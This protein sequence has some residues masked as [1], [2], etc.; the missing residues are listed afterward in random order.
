MTHDET[1][2]TDGNKNEGRKNGKKT[3]TEHHFNITPQQDKIG[4]K[5]TKPSTHILPLRPSIGRIQSSK[6][7]QRTTR[8]LSYE[9]KLL[10][11][12]V[13]ISKVN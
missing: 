12:T 11:S 13:S 6:T 1:E 4:R 8:V 2:T 7:I 10:P 5:D 3:R 9:H